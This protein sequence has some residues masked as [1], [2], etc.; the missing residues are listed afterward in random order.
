LVFNSN[1]NRR[2]PI[3]TWKLNNPLLNDNL[4]KE[5]I[6]REIKDFLEFNVNE[7]TTYP[8]LW[9]KMKAVLMGKLLVLSASKMKL[10]RA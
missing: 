6:K 4:V 9:D 5:E 1:K 7:G 2:K 8:N 3:Y 10:E